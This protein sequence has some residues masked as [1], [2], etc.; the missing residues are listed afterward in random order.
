MVQDIAQV[1][2]LPCRH[3]ALVSILSWGQMVYSKNLNTEVEKGQE[4]KVILD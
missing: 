2:H 1:E 3:Q 4:F